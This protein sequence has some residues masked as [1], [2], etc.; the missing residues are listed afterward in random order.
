MR[1]L[2][3]FD[4]LDVAPEPFIDK[5]FDIFAGLE[6]NLTHK[7]VDIR[8][9]IDR[10]IQRCLR[11]IELATLAFERVVLSLHVRSYSMSEKWVHAQL[12]R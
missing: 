7:Y 6:R 4:Q 1:L 2:R 10:Q 11:T 9:E 5:F 3:A 8:F 12:A